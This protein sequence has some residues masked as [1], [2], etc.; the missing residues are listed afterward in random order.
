MKLRFVT[1]SDMV[2]SMIRDREGEVEPFTPSH[3][4]IAVPEG[5]LGAHYDGG[6]Q[7]RPVGYDKADLLHEVFV[8]VAGADEAAGEAWARGRI[9]APYDWDAILDFVLPLR[10]H[11]GKHLICSAFATLACIKSRAFRFPLACPPHAISPRD[12]FLMLSARQD[13]PD[14]ELPAKAASSQA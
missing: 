13:I 7:I 5:Y 10:D 12:L 8:D 14:I 2:S 11:E 6:V 4:E 3:V 1:C 9:G